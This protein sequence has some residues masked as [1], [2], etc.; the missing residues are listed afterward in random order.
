MFAV[1]ESVWFCE[2]RSDRRLEKIYNEKPYDLF[3]LPNIIRL[4]KSRIVR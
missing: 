3:S 4:V 1:E 2:G